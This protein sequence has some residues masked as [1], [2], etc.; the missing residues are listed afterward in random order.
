VD[1]PLAPSCSGASTW[2]LG[3]FS[4]MRAYVINLDRA[5]ERM[6]NMQG[7]F[8]RLGISFTRVAAV[9]AALLTEEE[10][11]AFRASVAEAH[12]QHSWG[13][14]Q[15]GIFLSH[16]KV[17][18]RIA[19]STDRYAAI[20]EDDV[21]LS[22]RIAALLKNSDWI[23]E[24]ADIVRFETTI[25]GMRLARSPISQANEMRLF[26]VY[27]GAWGTAG[28]VIKREIAEWLACSPQ[29][30]YEPV[31]WFLFHPKS[32]LAQVLR[33]FQLDPA[34]C[35]QDHYHP[36]VRS[37]KNLGRQ[38]ALQTGLVQDVKTASRRLLSPVV[39]TVTG[40]RGIPYG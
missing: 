35:V 6:A 36:D 1:D 23:H 21:H 11:S 25:Q 29:R 17:W 27:S 30:L 14:A 16:K 15:I 34:P 4:D 2:S 9:D 38:T 32:A 7:Q 19:S 39:R 31:D 12:R 20:F 3:P 28:Y 26:Q 5:A 10:V 18:A 24:S 22:D 37:R 13:A 8:D 40:R 33:T